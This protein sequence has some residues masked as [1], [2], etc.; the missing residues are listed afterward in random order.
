MVAGTEYDSSLVSI[1][2]AR[3][4]FILVARPD[5]PLVSN[6]PISISSLNGESMITREPDPGLETQ[7]RKDSATLGWP[8]PY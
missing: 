2:F 8:R 6:A 5:H 1:P 7:W 3:A 4:E